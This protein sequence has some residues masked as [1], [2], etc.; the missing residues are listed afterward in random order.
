MRTP[1]SRN[2]SS[3]ETQVLFL[4]HDAIYHQCQITLHSM[5]VPLF[6]GIPADPKSDLGT[7]K[8]SA[9]AVVKHAELF[10]GLLEPY[11]CGKCHVSRLPP[12]VGYGAFVAGIVLLVTELSCQERD[13]NGTSIR[14]LK[15]NYRLAAVKSILRLLDDLRVYWTALQHPVSRVPHTHT[16][17]PIGS[18]WVS[19]FD[20]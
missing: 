1:E 3:S 2:D 6:S 11:V 5:N 7:Q 10:H 15:G 12:L 17:T 13:A 19:R 20:D 14:S 18:T 16:H 4:V 8:Q 9:K